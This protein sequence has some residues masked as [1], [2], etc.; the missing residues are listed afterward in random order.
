MENQFFDIN[1]LP[2]TWGI[3]VFP[4]SMSRIENSQSA[5]SCFEYIKIFDDKYKEPKV[6]AQFIYTEGLYMNFEERAYETK[7]KFA[8]RMVNHKQGLQKLI[9]K[10]FHHYQ[11]ANAFNFEAWFQMYLS[12]PDFFSVVAQAKMLYDT[13]TLFQKY[14]AEDSRVMERELTSQQ[15]NFL[16]EEHVFSYLL[17]NRQLRL[18]NEYINGREEWLLL[19]YPGKPLLSEI[20]FYQKDILK[21]NT[22]TNPYKGHYDLTQKRFYNFNEIDLENFIL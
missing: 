8:Q 18:Q 5:S 15:L 7:N 2:A 6:G 20:Y 14:V 11:I 17:L 9:A 21:I 3:L 16:I 10:N 22:D 12:H 1:K 4:I 19:C 13:D